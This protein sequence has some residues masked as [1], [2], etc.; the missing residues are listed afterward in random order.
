MNILLLTA[1][2][3]VAA[4]LAGLVYSAGRRKPAP[5]NPAESLAAFSFSCSHLANL[6]QL[7][8]ALDSADFEY[9]RNH[10]DPSTARR[11]RRERNRV[12]RTYLE[13]IHED[14]ANLMRATQLV[15]ALSPEVVAHQE[16]KRFH[17]N[18]EFQLKYRLLKAKFALGAAQFRSLGNLAVLVSSLAMDLERAVNE[19]G[20]TSLLA[21]ERTLSGR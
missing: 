11:L 6:S 17:L 4:L 9:V 7:R 5:P 10:L 20:A 16:W 3:A 8:Q 13:A 2:I 12:A 15:A 18:L 1:G 21:R 14:F 19:S